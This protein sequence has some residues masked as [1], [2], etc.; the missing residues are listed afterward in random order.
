VQVI[1]G[2]TT[3]HET[4]H[5]WVRTKRTP[6]MDSQ[7]HCSHE[8]YQQDGVEC[9]LHRPYEG[10]GL[11]DGQVYLHYEA[12]GSDSEYMWIRRE[13]DPLPLR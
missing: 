2:E 6:T 4:L 7:G 11:Y 3:A 12:H 13:T 5:F 10:G 9:L 1:N 8:R